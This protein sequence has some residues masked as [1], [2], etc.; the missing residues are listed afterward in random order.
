VNVTILREEQ[1][2]LSYGA[3][4]VDPQT[5]CAAVRTASLLMSVPEQL[6]LPVVTLTTASNSPVWV[7]VPS[8]ILGFPDIELASR[9]AT[10]A[11]R[12]STHAIVAP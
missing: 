9:L 6:E 10:L 8:A 11:N 7:G 3:A 12:I 4:H 2:T 1:L 5:Q